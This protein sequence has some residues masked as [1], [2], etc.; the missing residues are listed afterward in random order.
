MAN[1]TYINL[2]NQLLR[3]L[4]E[5]EIEQSD[6]ASA[7]GVQAMAKDAINSAI[8]EINMQE[9]EWPFNADSHSETL[10]AGTEEYTF[11]TDLKS[12]DWESFHLVKDDA[13]NTNGHHLQLISTDVR[14]KY[15]KN[16]DDNSGSDGLSVPSVIYPTPTGFG[17]SPSPDEAYEITYNY[18]KKPTQ[19]SAYGDQSTID[20]IYDEIIIQGGLYH[21]YMFRDN[22]E[23]AD[24]ALQR[25]RQ[26]INRMRTILIN[27]GQDDRMRST[28]L[29]KRRPVSGMYVNDYFIV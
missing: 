24:R 20:T 29:V 8:N 28:M 22:S 13:L 5:V 16:K 27:S 1:T 3:R 9:F 23:Q 10:V 18:F 7:R 21:F 15:L 6:F 14:Y 11:P 26:L 25:F 2:V 4:N 12:V 17:V 19:L